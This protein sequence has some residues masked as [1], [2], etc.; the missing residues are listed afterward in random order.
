[1]YTADITILYV[2]NPVKSAAF[3]ATL[4]N[5]QPV[6]V[7]PTFALFVM[8]NGFKLGLWSRFTVEPQPTH[9]AP[10]NAGEVFFK[11]AS[12]TAVDEVYQTWGIQHAVTIIQKPTALDFGYSFTALDPDGHRLRVGVLEAE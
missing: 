9:Y 1:M 2:T 12:R 7:S 8:S 5:T 11:V 4:L 10:G 3:Y 6:E